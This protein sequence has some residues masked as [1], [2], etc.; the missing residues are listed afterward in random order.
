[1]KLSASSSEGG[2]CKT[3]FDIP[4]SMIDVVR[5]MTEIGEEVRHYG[6]YSG[7]FFALID[8]KICFHAI[9]VDM[10]NISL[11]QPLAMLYTDDP[12]YAGYLVGTFEL[13][14]K[15]AIPAEERIQELLKRGPP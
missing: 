13:L 7:V 8:R 11:N 5:E 2:A 3:I 10:K 14:W 15:Q 12:T 9:N 1:M 4:Y 6:P